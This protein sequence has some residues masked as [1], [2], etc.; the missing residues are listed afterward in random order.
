[1]HLYGDHD[2]KDEKGS[3]HSNHRVQLYI[4]KI[5]KREKY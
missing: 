1:M 3:S 2:I 5:E 4:I